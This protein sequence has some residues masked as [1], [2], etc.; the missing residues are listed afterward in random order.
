MSECDLSAKR[1]CLKINLRSAPSDSE[2]I[3]EPLSM[4]LSS[5]E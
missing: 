3:Q 2:A 4:S 1:L 5:S